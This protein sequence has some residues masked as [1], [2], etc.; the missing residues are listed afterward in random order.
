MIVCPKC[1]IEIPYVG[2]KWVWCSKC[3]SWY[4]VVDTS[5]C[6]YNNITV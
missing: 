6:E 1:K 5:H 3:E 2:D 4:A